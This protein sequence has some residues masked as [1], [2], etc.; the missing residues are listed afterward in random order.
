MKKLRSLPVET[1]G[2]LIAIG[3]VVIAM[4]CFSVGATIAKQLFP[5]VGPSGA[6]ALRLG[7]AAAVMIPAFRPWRLSLKGSWP[8]LFIYGLCLA[9]MNLA[10]YASLKFIPLGIAIAVE[11]TGPLAVAI[12]TSKKKADFL[13]I[14]LAATGLIMILPL[15]SRAIALDYRGLL[16]AALAGTFWACYILA[17]KRAGDLHGPA[18]SSVGM[19][20]A[21]LIAAPI[22]ITQAGENLLLPNVLLLGL[23]LAV[24]SSAIPFSLEMMALRRLP[25]NTFGTM[26][27]IEPAIGAFIGMLVLGEMLGPSQ[28]FAIGLIV[29]ASTGAALSAERRGRPAEFSD[30]EVTSG[31]ASH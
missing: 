21:A 14:L 7:F 4:I 8:T 19:A 31:H 29:L 11:F 26:M 30:T 18:A 3:A 10:F 5:S 15:Q 13:W 1:Q 23:I 24:V 28:W 16:L 27:S 25:A 2:S 12:A 17:G 9:G 22:G 20:F 6:T